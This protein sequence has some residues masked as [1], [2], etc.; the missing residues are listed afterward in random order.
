ME[1][2]LDLDVTQASSFYTQE[3]YNSVRKDIIAAHQLLRSKQGS[4][5]DFLGWL[6][7]PV[8][9]DK[10]RAH[11]YFDCWKKDSVTVS[12]SFSYWYRWILF[13]GKGS[14]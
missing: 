11:R 3:E 1:K 4:G 10:K 9:Y 6:D 7:L 14:D 12:G 2:Y 5:N 8:E 13:R